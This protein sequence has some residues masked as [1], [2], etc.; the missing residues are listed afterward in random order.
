[1]AEREMKELGFLEKLG[2]DQLHFYS[3]DS[4]ANIGSVFLIGGAVANTN[5]DHA[6]QLHFQASVRGA[7]SREWFDFLHANKELGN[8]VYWPR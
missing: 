4:L 8:G 7:T 6:L 3:P 5:A 1:M 2:K